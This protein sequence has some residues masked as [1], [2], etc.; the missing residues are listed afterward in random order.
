MKH[1]GIMKYKILNLPI[2]MRFG[3][4]ENTVYPTLLWDERNIILVDCGFIGS[5]PL[6]ENEL[7]KYGLSAEQITG[8][9]LTHH[10]HDHMGATAALKRINPRMKIYSSAIEE[11]YISAK[12]KPLRLL[13]AEEMQKILPP[14][15]QD[16]GKAFCDMLRRVEPVDVDSFLRDGDHMEW[17]EGCR[18]IATPGHTPGHISLFMEKNSIIITGDAIALEDGK[19]V[20]ANPQFTLDVKKAEESMEKLLSMKAK[21]YYCYH[22]GVYLPENNL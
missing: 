5:L 14:E 16:F 15:Q 7:R 18:I 3:N 17:C 6:L 22:G 11:P 2:T 1:W 4:T 8:L 13:Q 10:D 21:A 9:V 12:E 20:I 19:P